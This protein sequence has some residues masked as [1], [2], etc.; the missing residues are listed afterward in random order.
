MNYA[1]TYISPCVMV[2]ITIIIDLRGAP[3]HD[4]KY[5]KKYDKK[6]EL[7]AQAQTIKIFEQ[8]GLH[9][10]ATSL[11]T[12]QELIY[13]LLTSSDQEQCRAAQ[14]VYRAINQKHAAM[15]HE[16]ERKTEQHTL[17]SLEHVYKKELLDHYR[18]YLR[19]FCART[20]QR[21]LSFL[22][23]IQ[24]PASRA[25]RVSALAH[26]LL[27]YYEI[28]QSDIL[29][30][31]AQARTF[32]I[33]QTITP[34]PELMATWRDPV[35]QQHVLSYAQLAT[36]RPRIQFLE[37]L[38]DLALQMS[39]FT[40]ESF[41]ES[42]FS[43]E[44]KKE[45]NQIKQDL[46]SLQQSFSTFQTQLAQSS[47]VLITTQS[48]AYLQKLQ[49]LSS[50]ITAATTQL[51]QE[52]TYLS[53]SINL[54]LPQSTY[55][56]N[57]VIYDQVFKASSMLTPASPFTWYNLYQGPGDWEYD[58]ATGSFVQRKRIPWEAATTADALYRGMQNSIFTE[59]ITGTHP[60]TIEIE[61]TLISA[62]PSFFAGILFNKARWLSGSSERMYQYR[63]L[64]LYGSGTE[65][66][67][68]VE[69]KFGQSSITTAQ[70]TVTVTPALATIINPTTQALYMLNPKTLQALGKDPLSF[71]IT[72]TNDLLTIG[73]IFAQR[74][75]NELQQLYTTQVTTMDPHQ[76]QMLFW[77]HG[78]GF[79]APGCQ[80]S[81]KIIQP[82]A[83]TYT[84][85]Q[86]ENFQ[87]SLASP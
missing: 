83:L 44:D 25:H 79:M 27:E 70:G 73:I 35:E 87:K 5:D 17:Q 39:V 50:Q 36:Q 75:D 84:E 51:N 40:G 34:L 2:I 67:R 4:K 62:N 31:Y 6:L 26:L 52:I 63:L 72:I 13:L 29:T 11:T 45:Y 61:L 81:F 48:T 54:D 58:A 20:A 41:A 19:Q 3:A 59:F 37:T 57:P 16:L 53:R 42:L 74:I 82:A 56:S 33:A 78:I 38:V 23:K 10:S 86:R 28:E 18:K 80:A 15:T 7:Q 1:I 66:N 21:H 60:Y 8:S 46:I 71:V 22:Q 24:L 64:G 76:S 30:D 43:A 55:V 49:Y 65:N 69:L 68:S 12:I 77:Y 47:K 32:F 9:V 14:A 85:Q